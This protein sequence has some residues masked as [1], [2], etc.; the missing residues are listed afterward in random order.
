MSPSR[1]NRSPAA[2]HSLVWSLLLFVALLRGLV[3]HAALA[4]LVDDGSPELRWCAPTPGSPPAS[5]ADLAAAFAAHSDC[6]CAPASDLLG[7]PPA[8]ALPATP[9]AQ[10]PRGS[11][12]AAGHPTGPALP[13]RARGPPTRIG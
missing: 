8:A 13:Q 6:A 12:V 1:A 10:L 3:P 9:P 2:R 4:A 11:V 7:P 5:A